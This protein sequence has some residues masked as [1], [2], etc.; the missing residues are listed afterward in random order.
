MSKLENEK[1]D[2]KSINIEKTVSYLNHS[3]A[4]TAQEVFGKRVAI[5]GTPLYKHQ[6]E[7]CYIIDEIQRGPAYLLPK[8]ISAANENI[9][10]MKNEENQEEST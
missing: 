5:K 9:S 3:F 10:I 7:H 6:V 4:T 8:T 1:R 2:A